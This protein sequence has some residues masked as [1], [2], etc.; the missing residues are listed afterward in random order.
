MLVVL[1]LSEEIPGLRQHEVRRNWILSSDSVKI[2]TSCWSV[3]SCYVEYRVLSEVCAQY[4]HKVR[5]SGRVV[6]PPSP[7]SCLGDRGFRSC[8]G[9]ISCFSL[10]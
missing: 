10:S 8:F 6:V 3:V 9:C 7:V 4:I 1:I 2:C 5:P